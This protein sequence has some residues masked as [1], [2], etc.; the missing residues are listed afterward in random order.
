MTLFR[1][2]GVR[3][4]PCLLSFLPQTIIHRDYLTGKYGGKLHFRPDLTPEYVV[5]GHE[6]SSP[7]HIHISAEQQPLFD[8]IVAHAD[9]FPGFLQ[10]EPETN[11]QPKLRVLRDLGFYSSR[12]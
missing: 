1:S 11:V 5:T 10:W 3:V 2:W 6:T 8:F 4:L 9:L 7:G 12:A